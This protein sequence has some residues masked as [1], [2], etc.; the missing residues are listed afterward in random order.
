MFRT[1]GENT[2]RARRG[3]LDSICE[4]EIDT[5]DGRK[6][7]GQLS[8]AGMRA[9]HVRAIR[10]EKIEFPEAENGRLKALGQL[11]PGQLSKSW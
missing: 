6:P 11:S 2:Q 4:G 3:V 1:L 5:P 10:D 7:R 8:I 9:K